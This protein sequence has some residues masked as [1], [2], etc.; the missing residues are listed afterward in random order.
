AVTTWAFEPKQL[1]S[2]GIWAAVL[3]AAALTL[4]TFVAIDRNTSLSVIG[5]STPG[6]VSFD[7]SFFVNV[8]TY[9]V[10]PLVGVI[11][12]QF[13]YFGRLFAQWFNPLMRLAGAE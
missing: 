8:F 10:I 4:W 2:F 6:K 9:G 3:G 7:R 1:V 11:T 12:T 13:P 5:G